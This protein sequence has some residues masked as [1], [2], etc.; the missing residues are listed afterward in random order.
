MDECFSYL[1]EFEHLKLLVW[2]SIS[3]E[4]AQRADVLFLRSVA[5]QELV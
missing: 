3:A 2:S 4:H 1:I 5:S